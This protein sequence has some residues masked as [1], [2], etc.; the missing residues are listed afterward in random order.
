MSVPGGSEKKNSIIKEKEV[1]M[2]MKKI[3]TSE[4]CFVLYT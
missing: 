2:C 3:S 1:F 4:T